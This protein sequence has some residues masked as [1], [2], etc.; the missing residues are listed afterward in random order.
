M[1]LFD[2]KKLLITLSKNKNLTLENLHKMLY[3]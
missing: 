2:F 1:Q 3:T